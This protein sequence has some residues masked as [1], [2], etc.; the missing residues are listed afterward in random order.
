MQF[1]TELTPVDPEKV[2]GGQGRQV[3]LEFA[4]VSS[5]QLPAAQSVQAVCASFAQ[6]PDLHSE[7]FSAPAAL[8][9]PGVQSLCWKKGRRLEIHV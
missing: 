8:M 6:P 2:P 3:V 7:H 9:W 5:D 4:P 1:S